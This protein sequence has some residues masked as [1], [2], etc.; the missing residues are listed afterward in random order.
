MQPQP[1]PAP[2]FHE[3][4]DDLAARIQRLNE[5]KAAHQQVLAFVKNDEWDQA[6]QIAQ[7]Y[8]LL[9]FDDAALSPLVLEKYKSGYEKQQ[10]L[11]KQTEAALEQF[12]AALR[13]HEMLFQRHQ[14]MLHLLQAGIAVQK[15]DV[16]ALQEHLRQVDE[17]S[18]VPLEGEF[19]KLKERLEADRVVL[20]RLK[21]SRRFEKTLALKKRIESGPF[22]DD[23][24]RKYLSELCLEYP[25]FHLFALWKQQAHDA[26]VQ[27]SLP[28]V[29]QLDRVLEDAE[30]LL[31]SGPVSINKVALQVEQHRLLGILAR[32]RQA[33]YDIPAQHF[34][35]DNEAITRLKRWKDAI[36]SLVDR[37][38]QVGDKYNKT[39]AQSRRQELGDYDWLWTDALKKKYSGAADASTINPASKNA[40]GVVHLTPMDKATD[41]PKTTPRSSKN[42]SEGN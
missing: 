3:I 38:Q 2:K 22:I 14:I 9:L 16:D 19:G 28:A 26:Q 36:H 33:Y 34:A 8:K 21:D 4:F 27:A 30:D 42:P 18:S 40:P 7:K 24:D 23:A 39:D 17:N 11:R 35:A 31:A 5:I 25:G 6:Y 13:K 10:D 20:L 37:L 29:Q 15:L 1:S 32:L 12:E 41:E